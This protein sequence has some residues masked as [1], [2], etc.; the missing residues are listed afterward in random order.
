MNIYKTVFDTQQQGKDILIEK[1]VWAE[2]TEDDVTSMVYTN[3]TQ[4]VVNIGK[5]V[6]TSGTY[7]EDGN[8]ITPPIYKDGWAYDIMSADDIDFGL[9]EVFPAD[10]SV[11]Q[12]Y[13]F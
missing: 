9:Y 13:G 5:I 1:G 6:E 12:F 7:D 2:I 11:H 3:G 8:E 4:A 10:K